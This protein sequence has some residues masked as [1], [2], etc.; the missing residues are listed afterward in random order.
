MVL[1]SSTVTVLILL[2]GEIIPKV[3]ATNFSI[4]FALA[5]SPIVR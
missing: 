3:F 5:V 1:I 2:F 4:Q